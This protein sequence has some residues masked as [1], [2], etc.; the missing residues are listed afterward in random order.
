MLYNSSQQLV[1]ASDINYLVARV[2]MHLQ[3]FEY[4]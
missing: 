3:H 1:N 2:A 4:E